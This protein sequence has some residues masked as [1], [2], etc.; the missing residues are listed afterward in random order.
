MAPASWPRPPASALLHS[1]RSKASWRRK[2][3]SPAIA[4]GAGAEFRNDALDA[5]LAAA[6]APYSALVAVAAARVS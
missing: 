6:L 1:H 3:V 4:A 5:A 2:I